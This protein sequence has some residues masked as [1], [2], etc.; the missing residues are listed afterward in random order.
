M[1][2]LKVAV[3]G[4][5]GSGKS[6]V[7]NIIRSLGYKTISL[8]EVYAQLLREK[9]FLVDISNAF[10]I[11][12]IIINDNYFLN[13]EALSNKVFNDKNQL[14]KLN[15]I[16]HGAI[17]KKAFLNHSGIVFYEV[18]L[19]FEGGY[20]KL[21]DKIIVVM[22]NKKDRLKSAMMR[23]C[24]TEEQILR[25]MNNQ[26]DYDNVDL[27]EYKVIDNNGDVERLK[28]TVI[29]ALEGIL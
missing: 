14:K 19:L 26:I 15:E 7:L 10:D 27:S 18:P 16:T 23:D 1:S 6:Q 13:K 12:P 5:I 20:Q 28:T 22:R 8:D 25:K 24:A 17:F 21:F 29:N 4:G 3:T 11:D 9:D 2:D